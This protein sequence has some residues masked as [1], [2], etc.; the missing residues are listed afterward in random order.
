[1]QRKRSA[2]AL[3]LMF[4]LVL[5]LGAQ[6]GLARSERR[7]G[8]VSS[9]RNAALGPAELQRGATK[10]ILPL[11]MQHRQLSLSPVGQLGG[12]V[13]AVT[14][15]GNRVYFGQGP[16]LMVLDTSLPGHPVLLGQSEPLPGVITDVAVD[17]HH[18]YVVTGVDGLHVLDLG[19]PTA[20]RAVG[21]LT[22]LDSDD[23][24]DVVGHFAYVG[25]V[26]S[27]LRIIDVSDPARP[28]A[29]GR[30]PMVDSIESLD[31]VDGRAYL[32]VGVAGLHI[33]DVADPARPRLLGRSAADVYAKDVRVVG[34]LAYTT[35]FVL[36]VFDVTDP[37]SPRVLSSGAPRGGLIALD[38]HAEVAYAV[39]SN[40]ISVF[41]VDNPAEPRVLVTARS[42]AD[43]RQVRIVAGYA[44]IA[45]AA[46]GLRVLERPQGEFSDE[47]AVFGGQLS[48]EVMAV[49]GG[50]AY[51]GTSP[52]GG[53]L[54]D[55]SVPHAPRDA[56]ALPVTGVVS[57]IAVA[58]D[59]AYVLTRGDGL[60]LL[61]VSEP[62][63]VRL[64]GR[65]A[66][67]AGGGS[68]DVVGD[69]AMLAAFSG[70]LHVFDMAN[71]RDPQAV[72]TLLPDVAFVDVRISGGYA[73]LAAREQGLYVVDIADRELPRVVSRY[74][75]VDPATRLSV[76]GDKAYVVVRNRGLWTLD[77][78]DPTSPRE[79]AVNYV[80]FLMAVQSWRDVLVTAGGSN[81]VTLLGLADPA[82]PQSIATYDTPG[83]AWDLAVADDH[84]YVADGD[85]G[86]F[87]FRIN[88]R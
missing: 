36:R 49:Q 77:V 29:V 76:T 87:V 81:G 22:A 64:V 23:S 16:R 15:A 34:H 46:D 80:F 14:Q 9:D 19:D 53:R 12:A 4:L 21:R 51:L 67:P 62:D 26:R 85:G 59:I 32:A 61:D 6:S 78:S 45:C 25:T 58:G 13:W 74:Q 41:A 55:V 24:V 79:R 3:R 40:G 69:T 37:A 43:P 27:G 42:C 83:A 2:A 5:M 18:A 47:A 56:G 75:T 35:G 84:V 31:V 52:E 63:S 7:A 71:P 48:G 72:T 66:T 11:V 88:M 39:G 65:I 70:G 33:V 57:D 17:G 1:M 60:Q 20:P 86:L 30:F 10:I 82:A 73:Y 28:L 68:V 50:Y 54:V 38:I 44:Y 8:A